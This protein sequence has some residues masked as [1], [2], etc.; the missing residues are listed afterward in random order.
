MAGEDE[1]GELVDLH[2]RG[3][4]LVDD[5]ALGEGWWVVKR[6]QGGPNMAEME[7]GAATEERPTDEALGKMAVSIGR[8]LAT[9]V[10]RGQL[11]QDEATEVTKALDLLVAK[12]AS[13]LGDDEV[14][15][16]KTALEQLDKVFDQLP[17]GLQDAVKSLRD[18]VGSAEDEAGKKKPKKKP[19]EYGYPGPGKASKAEGGAEPTAKGGG[20]G[21]EPSGGAGAAPQGGEAAGVE[22]AAAGAPAGGGLQKDATDLAGLIAGQTAMSQFWQLSDALHQVSLNIL[23]SE[24]G[25]E[26]RQNLMK[27]AL[28]D[29]NARWL[30]AF[31]NAAT[32]YQPEKGADGQLTES[33]KRALDAVTVMSGLLDVEKRGARFSKQS[34]IAIKSA[35]GKIEDG[36]KA[37]AALIGEAT[38]EKGAEPEESE[39]S[40]SAGGAV[41]WGP[42]GEALQELVDWVKDLQ[43]GVVEV[44]TA[45]GVVKASGQRPPTPSGKPPA[46]GRGELTAEDVAGIVRREIAKARAPVY[47]SLGGAPPEGSEAEGE[48]ESELRKRLDGMPPLKRLDALNRLM[49]GAPVE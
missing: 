6:R 47:K 36:I 10:T 48:D 45:T 29:F 26:D 4:D 34:V 20:E 49:F 43:A 18:A 24:M 23:K 22:K 31:D 17:K 5:P 28:G 3:V 44:A 11:S 40:K 39:T 25:A 30:G 12:A 33:S 35:M 19:D 42:V 41:Q 37:L 27:K 16:I 38:T 8:G 46:D 32:V 2:V 1:V 21:G 13:D 15:A 7:P 9:L 14:K